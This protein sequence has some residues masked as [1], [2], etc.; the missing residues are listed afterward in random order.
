MSASEVKALI[1][2][3]KAVMDD[4]SDIACGCSGKHMLLQRLDV[5]IVLVPTDSRELFV[6]PN[7]LFSIDSLTTD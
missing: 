6:D 3:A 1:Y 5:Y 7:L 2:F 4:F